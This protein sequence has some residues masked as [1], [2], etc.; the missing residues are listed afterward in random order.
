MTDTAEQTGTEYG[1]RRERVGWYFYDFA[2]SAFTTTV[3]TVF[4]GPYL[5]AVAERAAGCTS[6]SDLAAD[7][8]GYLLHPLGIPVSPGA[9]FPYMVS[10]SVLL[11]VFVLPVLGAIAD[12]SER[13]RE[14]LAGTAF[15]GAAATI[16]LVF[17]TGDRY[18][19]GGALFLVA[20]IA[21][22][23]SIVVYNSFLPQIA[24]PDQRDSVSSIGWAIGYLGGGTLLLLNVVAVL[25][26]SSLGW[27]A[28]EVARWRR[29]R[30]SPCCGC[31][32]AHRSRAPAPAT[33]SGSASGSSR[34]RCASSGGTR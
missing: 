7:C 31:A 28:A 1:T 10:L 19:L 33:R 11:T 24:P 25:A 27:S 29:S 3:V 16:G 2:N 22:G 17:L 23:A 21:Y 14:L 26:G 20:N 13:K 15:L 18:L 12:R 8:P 32:T 4:L 6:E 30:R 9:F 34:A 5:T